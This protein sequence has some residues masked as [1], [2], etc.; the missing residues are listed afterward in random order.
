MVS[1]V[2][3]CLIDFNHLHRNQW[4]QILFFYRDTINALRDFIW[5][6]TT[7][8]KKSWD[9]MGKVCLDLK[10]DLERIVFFQIRKLQIVATTSTTI[11][12]H[13]KEL[14]IVILEGQVDKTSLH[15]WRRSS[16]FARISRK[17]TSTIMCHVSFHINAITNQ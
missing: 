6:V 9:Q 13:A 16:F 3:V 7:Q 1:Y 8:G 15:A 12:H 4:L 10:V 2:P 17:H 14:I 5:E 11:N